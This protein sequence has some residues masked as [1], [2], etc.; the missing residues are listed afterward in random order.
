LARNGSWAAGLEQ[1]PDEAVWL[2][3]GYPTELW[4]YLASLSE[5]LSSAGAFQVV[6]EQC[7]HVAKKLRRISEVERFSGPFEAS[8]RWLKMQSMM[9]I[10]PLLPGTATL[11]WVER[12][13]TVASWRTRA[14]TFEQ[15]VLLAAGSPVR[16]AEIYRKAVGLSERNGR[17]TLARPLTIGVI[18]HQAIEWSL[19]GEGGR[20]GL[21]KE[22]P[23]EFMPVALELAEALWHGEHSE[24]ERQRGDIDGM[25]R[26]FV[27]EWSEEAAAELRRT[28]ERY[29]GDL[30]DDV[31]ELSYWRSIPNHRHH[32]RCL[33]AIHECA[34][35]CVT[36]S[37]EQ[38]I[39]SVLPLMRASRLASVQSILLDILLSRKE[40]PLFLCNLS[41]LVADSRL[42]HA[43]GIEYWLEQGLMACWSSP[44]L[45]YA[46]PSVIRRS[47]QRHH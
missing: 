39:S 42:Y 7:R 25:M 26:Q 18:D 27:P 32:A 16:G 28:K 38:F 23:V 41:T 3:E 9:S 14:A 40:Q 31:A 21:L 11:A 12:E 44:R 22:H 36:D 2:D 35:R 6:V 19:A 8:E 24:R 29:L 34:R 30:I 33:A 5:G 47:V 45:F 20:R 13:L 10:I 17:F 43:T 15:L 1:W 46:V 37:P 4:L